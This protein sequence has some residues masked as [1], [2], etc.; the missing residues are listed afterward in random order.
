MRPAAGGEEMRE[1]HLERGLTEAPL[2]L[3]PPAAGKKDSA[4]VHTSV[5]PPRYRDAQLS[6]NAYFLSSRV[7]GKHSLCGNSLALGSWAAP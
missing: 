4:R 7:R 1:G 6:P 2:Q 5:P 3:G